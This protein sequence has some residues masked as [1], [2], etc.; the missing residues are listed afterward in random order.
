MNATAKLGL[1]LARGRMFALRFKLAAKFG[2][3]KSRKHVRYCLLADSSIAACPVV[4]AQC[5]KFIPGLA[6]GIGAA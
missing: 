4:R 3:A 1:S 6:F 5:P 2:R